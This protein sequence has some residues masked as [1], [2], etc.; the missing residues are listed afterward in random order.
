MPAEGTGDEAA[1]GRD[2][3][4]GSTGEAE[5]P[6]LVQQTAVPFATEHEHTAVEGDGRVAVQTRWSS[7]P[8]D[9]LPGPGL[10]VPAPQVGPFA[11]VTHA[12]EYVHRRLVQNS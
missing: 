5:S 10:E 9:P 7:G 11:Q 2:P 4:P 12:A 8:L 1:G 3:L 6:Q